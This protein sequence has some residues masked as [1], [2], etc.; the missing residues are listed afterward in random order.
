M[1]TTTG[2]SASPGGPMSGGKIYAFNNLGT[3][4]VL[5][6]P[7][8]P[9]RVQ[10]VFHNPGANNLYIAPS[11]VQASNSVPS[12]LPAGSLVNQTL[13]P[14]TGALGGCFIVGAGGGYITLTGECQG[15]YQAFAAS[16]SNNP[17]TV[18]DNN[19]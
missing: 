9:N 4:P 3:S 12:S 8:N 19:G 2:F 16:G 6:A 11:Q 13:T 14:S 7:A 15:S 5:V 1:S 18:S 10:I 17:L